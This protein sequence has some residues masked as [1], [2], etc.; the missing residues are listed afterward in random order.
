MTRL[1][2][3]IF[4]IVFGILALSFT[5]YILLDTFILERPSDEQPI[6]GPVARESSEVSNRPLPTFESSVHSDASEI[7]IIEDTSETEES[8]TD[9]SDPSDDSSEAA[10][11]SKE[12][13]KKEEK[14]KE[15]KSREEKS[16]DTTS[17]S[18]KKNSNTDPPEF[19]DEYELIGTY[20]N[21]NVSI[22]VRK[23]RNL[24]SDIWFAEI[25]VANP[26]YLKTALCRDTYG[27]NVKDLTSNIAKDHN[28]I[29]AINGDA[30]TGR[31]A[32]YVIR[33]GMLYRQEKADDRQCLAIYDDG[34]FEIV[35]E[36]KVDALTLLNNYAV[37][38]LSFGPG[39]LKDGEIIVDENTEIF[40][41]GVA[42][43][44]P[45]T[46]LCQMGDCHYAFVVVDGRSDDNRGARLLELAQYLQ[47]MGVKTAYNLDGGGTSVMYFNGKVISHPFDGHNDSERKVSDIVYIP[48]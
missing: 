5:L 43:H 40:N 29:L 39:L 46:V 4:T 22:S 16:R 32:G 21:D 37:H 19:S 45:R 28:A 2:R 27:R 42:H 31:E 3:W 23:Y 47:H 35:D 24:N 36:K 11:S 10:E 17:K 41:T 26:S 33:N 48:Q 30:Y 38:V 7:K 18:Q 6:A 8:D 25:Y 44:N 34:R 13:S 9:E 12:V 20:T 14:S 1:K 15:E